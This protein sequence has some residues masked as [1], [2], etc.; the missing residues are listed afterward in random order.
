MVNSRL[1]VYLLQAIIYQ[2]FWNRLLYYGFLVAQFFFRVRFTITGK[3][4]LPKDP[5]YLVVVN[6]LGFLDI[7]LTFLSLPKS[8][9]W[10]LFAAH[11]WKS[12]PLAGYLLEKAGAIFIDRENFDRKSL[13]K[14]M[15]AIKE[16][17]V[18]GMAPE[19]TRS[20]TGVMN[21]G[22]DGA[23][24]L[25]S[26]VN[27]PIVPIGLHNTDQWQHNWPWRLT[28]IH[29]EIGEPFYLPDLGRRVRG[30][31]LEAYTHYIMVKI[32][33]QI[34]DRYHGYYADSPALAAAVEGKDPWPFC[35][36]ALESNEEK[37]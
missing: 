31:D 3:E 21:K 32:A 14:A 5:P 20:K 16:G 29:A 8:T 1:V 26:R 22:R 34:P 33:L 13:A 35:L 37:S 24:Y 12:V 36:A 25:A 6:H 4:R 28:R 19:G 15:A 23:A 2:M 18:F 11:T 30:S 17:R 9:P 7:P 10:V 27:L